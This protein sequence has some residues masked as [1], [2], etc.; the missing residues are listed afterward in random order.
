MKGTGI[1]DR[2]GKEIKIGD[3]VKFW[4]QDYKGKSL[5]ADT[6]TEYYICKVRK[7]GED[8]VA[9][10]IGVQSRIMV[11]NSAISDGVVQEGE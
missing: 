2:N 10:G 11:F 3:T 6:K 5:L 1:K 8:I 9:E 7:D 4:N